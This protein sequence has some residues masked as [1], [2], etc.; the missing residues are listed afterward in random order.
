MR[1][2]GGFSRGQLQLLALARAY[3]VRDICLTSQ[4]DCALAK[5]Q[6]PLPRRQAF[7][8]L[9]GSRLK[10]VTEASASLDSATDQAIQETLRTAFLCT[11]IVIAHRIS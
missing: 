11:L 2:T 3:L 6:N 4:S 8:L 1:Y 5:A 10:L 9:D 7:H